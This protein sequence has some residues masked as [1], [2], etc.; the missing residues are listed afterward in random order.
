MAG[1][2]LTSIGR[3][4]GEEW[5]VVVAGLGENAEDEL[6]WW[7]RTLEQARGQPRFVDVKL[8]PRAAEAAAP[9][10]EGATLAEVE[11]QHIRKVL[12]STGGR[13][14]EAARILGVHRNTLTRKLKALKDVAPD[15]IS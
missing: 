6:R 1:D 13:I 11:T 15:D 2:F 5:A 10:L 14:M 9:T 4:L 7:F 12:E 8:Q 3:L